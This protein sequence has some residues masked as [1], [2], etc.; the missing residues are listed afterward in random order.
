MLDAE[1][2]DYAERYGCDAGQMAWR[3][4]K[5]QDDFRGD[6]S[7]F[8]QEYPAT[9]TLAF[10]RVAGNPY[11]NIKL[12][13]AARGQVV[14]GHGAKI[15]GVDVAEYGDDD[16]AIAF[17][18]GRE[19]AP[20]KHAHGKGPMEVVGWVAIEA[21][22]WKPD[23]INVDC[24]GVG[25]GVADRL[26]ELGYP[27]QRVHFGSRAILEEIYKDR[28]AEMYGELKKWL[29]DLPCALPDDDVLVGELSGPQ[30]TYDSSRR[31]VLESKEKMRE[32]GLKSP[33][34][35]DALALTFAVKL[36]NPQAEK[37]SKRRKSSWR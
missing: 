17:R 16:S 18:Q 4:K 10:Q 35:A 8:D 32:R 11:I 22:A 1:E 15:M 30:Y 28:R 9:P 2:A 24:T 25:S 13:E 6:E 12:I 14:E 20:I 29:E 27:V 36:A 37:S 21:D 33:D 23:L 7:L 34:R 31:I 19:V 26:L 5:I 3:R